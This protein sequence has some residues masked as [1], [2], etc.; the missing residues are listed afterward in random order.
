MTTILIIAIIVLNA[1]AAL[2]LYSVLSAIKTG[3]VPK[4]GYTASEIISH[5]QVATV[6]LA[7][8]MMFA[9]IFL[10]RYSSN[11]HLNTFEQKLKLLKGYGLIISDTTDLITS[12][13]ILAYNSGLEDGFKSSY[14]W[15]S[16]KYASFIKKT[17]TKFSYLQNKWCDLGMQFLKDYNIMSSN[18]SNCMIK[19]ILLQKELK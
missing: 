3:W 15:H 14:Y 2:C 12:Y 9:I 17:N 6:C 11:E 1:A 8:S 16:N 13:S 4:N 18:T 7:F 5:S 10:I 19:T